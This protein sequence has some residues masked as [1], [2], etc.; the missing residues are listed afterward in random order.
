MA[1][2]Q[3]SRWDDVGVEPSAGDAKYVSGEQPIAEHDNWFN[4]AVVDD[5]S[6]LNEWLDN[7]GITKVYI[8][9]EA[10]MP[11]SG[12]ITELFITTDTNK[13]FR[14]TGT[15][16]QEICLT[17]DGVK[18]KLESEGAKNK[19]YDSDVDGVLD[20]AAIPNLLRS[21]ITDFFSSPF[22][23]NIP[24]KPSAYPPSSHNHDDRYYTES[25]VDSIFEKKEESYIKKRTDGSYVKLELGTITT[26]A[27][28]QALNIKMVFDADS[29]ESYLEKAS[30][31]TENSTSS[32]SYVDDHDFGNVTLS[33]INDELVGSKVKFEAE[34]RACRADCECADETIWVRLLEDGV[35]KIVLSQSCN[36][37]CTD[38]GYVTKSGEFYTTKTS[39]N[40]KTQIKDNQANAN[41]NF[42]RN[43]KIYSKKTY[44]KMQI[45]N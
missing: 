19:A 5:I 36:W 31:A 21:K 25:E 22:W 2:T 30:Y 39:P 44:Y 41:C 9:T 17:W 29:G 20:I 28:G 8:D 43:R 45:Y 34:L 37:P 40:L 6:A 26:L 15:G 4:K 3:K 7:L 14:G 12:A 38:S 32:T 27:D 11:E 13:L 23:D 33:T 10:N 24:D 1:I 16:W 18:S 35:E 42:I